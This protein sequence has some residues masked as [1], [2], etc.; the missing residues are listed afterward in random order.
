MAAD[1]GSGSLLRTLGQGIVLVV[2][3]DIFGCGLVVDDLVPTTF[4]AT[5][6]LPLTECF[7][8][9]DGHQELP[10]VDPV[11]QP[12]EPALGRPRAQVV[13]GAQGRVLGILDGLP[14]H[15]PEALMRHFDHSRNS[16]AR[17]RRLPRVVPP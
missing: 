16:A 5:V 8:D 13:N 10:E 11:A 14:G 1:W 12:L 17:V 2:I 15:W 4:Q 9:G 3:A 6:P 7:L